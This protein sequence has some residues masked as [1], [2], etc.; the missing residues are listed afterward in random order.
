MVEDAFAGYQRTV[1]AEV[2]DNLG[3]EIFIYIGPADQ[4]TSEQCTAMF[5]VNL[6]GVPG[7]LYKNEITVNLHPKLRRDPLIGGGHPRCRHH[8]S[9]IT[10]DYAVELG[11]EVKMADN[12]LSIKMPKLSVMDA[13]E[14][15]R[16]FD[17]EKQF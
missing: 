16:A 11:F 17:L 8:W 6:H 2:A 5:N 9:P 7:M 13:E 15:K 1:Q 3:M 10:T 14:F 4:I 12:F